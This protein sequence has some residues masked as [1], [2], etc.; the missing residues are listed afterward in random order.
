MTIVCVCVCVRNNS[1]E[2]LCCGGALP[3]E[4]PSKGQ[5]RRTSAI[6]TELQV[7]DWIQSSKTCGCRQK[8]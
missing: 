3:G 2:V 7:K 8:A 6:M 5:L 1:L 4:W